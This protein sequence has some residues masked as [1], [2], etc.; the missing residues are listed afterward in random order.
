[1]YMGSGDGIR[2]VLI[3]LIFLCLYGS[4]TLSFGLK[5]IQDNWPLYRCNPIIMPFAGYISPTG[6]STSDNFSYCVQNTISSFAPVLT[7]PYDYA[8]SLTVSIVDNLHKS[9][10]ATTQQQSRLSFNVGT[11]LSGVFDVFVNVV[12]LFNVLMVKLTDTQGKLMGVVTTVMNIMRTTDDT[13][14]SMWNGIPG[15]MLRE[16]SKLSGR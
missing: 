2:T 13:F 10:T 8:Q 9:T 11:T 3:L 7:E 14:N 6:T 4:L 1:M 16:V 15:S 5:N 12:I